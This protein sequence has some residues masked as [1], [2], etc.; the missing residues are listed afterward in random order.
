MLE[1]STYT[2]IFYFSN[3]EHTHTHPTIAKYFTTTTRKVSGRAQLRKLKTAK[4]TVKR[5]D[6]LIYQA[7]RCTRTTFSVASPGPHWASLQHSSR[8]RSGG[9]GACC[10]SPKTLP[11]S[12]SLA[13]DY[14]FS[15]VVSESRLATWT[16][17]AL[18]EVTPQHWRS[19]I[20]LA[21][22]PGN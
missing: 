7:A 1:G 8:P 22:R 4:S 9:N 12:R 20:K 17:Q 6:Y 2:Y 15:G 5:R 11:R 3:P 14:R 21:I 16:P 19:E 13:A 10:P 18:T